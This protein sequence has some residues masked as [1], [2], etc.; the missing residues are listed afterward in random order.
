MLLRLVL[1]LVG[2]VL[3]PGL[4]VLSLLGPVLLVVRRVVLLRLRLGLLRLHV[5]VLLGRLGVVRRPGRLG[6]HEVEVLHRRGV[7][8]KHL[9]RVAV[10]VASHAWVVGGPLLLVLLVLHK[11]VACFRARSDG[12]HP[13]QHS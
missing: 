1:R 8:A 4:H 7:L 11:Q 13:K 5:L 10:P 3:L 9:R 2:V 6:G 12:R